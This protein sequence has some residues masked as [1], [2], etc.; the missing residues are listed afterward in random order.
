MPRSGHKRDP[1]GSTTRRD[2]AAFCR[3]QPRGLAE[4]ASHLGRDSVGSAR[5]LVRGLVADGVLDERV[6]RPP[7]RGP[8]YK[9]ASS[10]YG[11]VAQIDQPSHRVPRGQ[12]RVVPGVR[13]LVIGGGRLR[14]IAGLLADALPVDAVRWAARV[15][16]DTSLLLMLDGVTGTAA[17][18]LTADL[19]R[20]NAVVAHGRV[21]EA[22][23]GNALQAWLSQLDGRTTG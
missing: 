17:D 19:A 21:D 18:V 10:F 13:V 12:E 11:R 15:D 6:S 9:L 4:I 22:L 16:G 23:D 8:L 2:V 3:H 14:Q 20:A 7:A 1:L 5:S